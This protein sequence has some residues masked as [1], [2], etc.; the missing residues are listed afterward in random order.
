VVV[1]PAKV[2][3]TNARDLAAFL[4]AKPGAYNFASSGN[5]TVLHLAGAMLI[6]ELGADLRHVPYKGVAPMLT[7]VIGGQ[8]E[9]AV[10]ALPTVQG[11]LRSGALRAIGV[12]SAARSPAAPDIPTF[13]EQGYPNYLAEGWFAAV[14]PARLPPEV[15]RRLHAALTAAFASTEVRE[16]M[17][18]QGNTV[19]ITSPEA[20][21]AYFRSE[22]DKY[23]R[24]VQKAGIKPE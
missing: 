5:G 22:R 8:V 13:A 2:S 16:T 7:D 6:D 18:K 10:S 23:A 4:K 21:L 11:H 20:A 15:V 1:N 9:L 3:A 17:A 19:S 12:G 24:L 14:G